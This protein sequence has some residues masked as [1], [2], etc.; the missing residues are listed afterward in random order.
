MLDTKRRKLIAAAALAIGAT[1][2]APLS[3]SQSKEPLKFGVAMPAT[4]AEGVYGADFTL[5]ARWAVADINA[6]GGING[7]PLEMIALDT[8]AEPALGITTVNRLI[9]VDKVPVFMVAWSGVVKA[10]APIANREKVLEL[11]V[12]ANSPD[13]AKLGD[14]VYTTFPLAEVDVTALAGYVHD[15][16]GKKTAAVMYINNDSGTEGARIYRSV[17]EKAGGKVVAF[18]AYDPKATDFSGIV[19]KVRSANPEIV[20]IHGLMADTPLVI[21][22][23]RQLGMNQRVTSYGAAY[24]VKI[25]ER[26][27]PQ[28]NGLLVTSLS[29]GAAQSPNVAAFYKRWQDTEKRVS[30]VQGYTQYVYDSVVL[31]GELYKW[32]LDKGLPP[33][34]ENLRKALLAIRKFELP[35]TGPLEIGDDHRVRKPVF[36]WTVEKEQFVQEAIVK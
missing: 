13:I 8:R 32:V 2:A 6:K 18:E 20:H 28:A 9:S 4:G 16:L 10:V 17:F 3:W 24:N 21:A 23:M 35:M 14:Y 15:K 7:R 29:P 36:L 5:V 31:I 27:G 25:I 11:S 33:T 22:Q 34:G 1:L 12:G 30:A 26:L 19:Q